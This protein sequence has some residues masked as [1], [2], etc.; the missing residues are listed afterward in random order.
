MTAQPTRPARPLT[1]WAARV[2][3]V[4]A[5][6][7]S[8]GVSP[9]Q[10][11]H[12]DYPGLVQN[13]TQV[14]TAGLDIEV[15]WDAPIHE[16]AAPV[17][18]YRVVLQKSSTNE[19]WWED[20]DA[21]VRSHTWPAAILEA[22]ETYTTMIFVFNGFDGPVGVDTNSVTMPGGV[23]APS[24]PSNA[25]AT[26]TGPDSVTVTWDAPSDDGGDP[27]TGYSVDTD[28][29][30]NGTVAGSI[31][32]FVVSDLAPGTYEFGIVADNSAG[33]SERA[34]VNATVTVTVTGT[35]PATPRNVTAVQ[36][37]PGQVTISWVVP[38]DEGSSPITSY[39]VGLAT[40]CYGDG[41]AHPATAR[42]VVFNDLVLGTEYTLSVAA[43]NDAGTGARVM[44]QVTIGAWNPPSV[45]QPVGAAQT[46]GGVS[47]DVEDVE[48]A[49][50]GRLANTG[51][52]LGT[53][54]LVG[55]LVLIAGGA[56]IRAGRASE[57]VTAVAGRSARHL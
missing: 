52:D 49:A 43:V 15:T 28:G 10:A 2:A 56:L 29:A 19:Q 36:T 13:P 5:L 7:G 44:R 20:H 9:A 6:I 34:T 50:A 47:G 48:A 31:R 33:P 45:A 57:G 54:A 4:I 12:T 24:A 25:A 8:V 16:G 17:N 14:I 11:D 37:G 30:T 22:G 38:V 32:S 3:V 35:E 27:V 21:T 41:Y 46:G 53:L 51:T 39:D 40:C 18:G 26:Q 55:L 23:T 1:R 42:S